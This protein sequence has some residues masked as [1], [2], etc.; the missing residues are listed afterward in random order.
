[1]ATRV[2]TAAVW[3]PPLQERDSTC[4]GI[5]K[6]QGE[7]SILGPETPDQRPLPGG[8]RQRHK[9]PGTEQVLEWLFISQEQ[10]KAK[11]T[12]GPL[13]FMDVFVDFT[14]EEWQL[15]DPAQKHLYRSVMLENYS[16]LVS[17]GYQH[18]KPNIIFQLEQE[19]L[20]MM[21]IPSEGHLDEVWE[22]DGRM[23]WHKENQGKLRT[24]CD[25]AANSE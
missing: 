25:H 24:K 14:W 19:E 13:S 7:G 18:T 6:L 22:I 17:L 16:N 2:R 3:V 8:P 4:D 1:M 11:K 9:S 15:L 23:E 10:P 5:R 20:W 12:W 21:Q